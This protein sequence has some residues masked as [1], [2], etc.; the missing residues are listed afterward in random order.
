MDQAKKM[1]EAHTCT[2][3]KPTS[4]GIPFNIYSNGRGE[5]AK[6][7]QLTILGEILYQNGSRFGLQLGCCESHVNPLLKTYQNQ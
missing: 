7:T 3:D 2:V 6:I 4:Y 1:R 5:I